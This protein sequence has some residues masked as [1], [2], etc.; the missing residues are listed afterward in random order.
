MV[1]FSQIK[2]IC[3]IKFL[4][5]CTL[6][7]NTEMSIYLFKH[8]QKAYKSVTAMLEREGMAAV[9]HP[10]GTGKSLIAF[11]LAEEHPSSHFLWLSPSEYIFQTQI[12]NLGMEFENIHF[13]SYSRLMRNEDSIETLHPD[14]IILDEFHRCGATEWGKSVRKLLDTYPDAKRLGLSATNIRYLDN[15]RNMAEEIFDGKIASEM[16]LGEAI[17]REILPEP[18]YVIAMYSYKKELDQLKKRVQALSNQG[19]IT[20]NQ[21]LLEQLRRALQ[22]AD[23]LDIVFEKHMKKKNSKYIVFCSDKEHMDEM[24]EQAGKWFRRVDEKPHIYTAFYNDTS[25]DREF[26][27]FKKDDSEHLKLLFCIDMLNEGVHVDD[28][29]G[30]ILLRPTVSP[31]IYLQQIG[32]ALSA[33]T[34][35]TPVIFDL[36]NNFDSLCCIDCLKKE[37]EEAYIL[38]PTTYGKGTPFGDRFHIVDETKDCRILFQKLQTNLSSA[39]ETYYI[40]AKQYYQERGNLKIPKNYLTPTGLTLGSWIQT[41]RRV[42]SGTVTG[43]LTE[44]KVRKLDE[45][46]MIWDSR[47]Q[48]WNE[49]LAELQAYFDEHGNLDVKARYETDNGFKLGR[50]V[51]NL[52][53]KVKNKGLDQVLTKEQQKQLT[54]L[55]MIWDRNSEK[56]E[57]YFRA[58][59]TYYLEHGNLNVPAKY[60]TETGLPLGR[61]LSEI[62]NQAALSEEQRRRLEEIGFRREKKTARQWNEKFALAKEYYETHGNLN[63]PLSYSV[64]GVKLGRWISNI[65]SKRKHPE[66]SGMVLDENRIGQLDRIGMDWK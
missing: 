36:V 62:S 54:A 16:T 9:I 30:V 64:E 29:D 39:W 44:E 21:K 25:T 50:W 3:E 11:R 20:E 13:M 7:R 35:K 51:C 41:Q 40:A 22:Q 32:R 34:D 48:S 47:D 65:R 26:Q 49:A 38:F 6:G 23:G 19:L 24:K 42:R 56:W 60:V 53:T 8:N 46:G 5:Q 2:T 59:R 12:E 28:V 4:L 18:K 52:R 14:Y 1:S 31:I 45:I 66:S 17:V 15:Q 61:W 10:T 58:A 43:N 37:M 63:I 55:G 33:G 27:T 57:E